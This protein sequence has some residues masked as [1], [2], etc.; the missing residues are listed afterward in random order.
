MQKKGGADFM[1]QKGWGWLFLRMRT[2]AVHAY[3]RTHLPYKERWRTRRAALAV[4]R[5]RPPLRDSTLKSKH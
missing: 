4:R 2:T 1:Q 5:Q 3:G